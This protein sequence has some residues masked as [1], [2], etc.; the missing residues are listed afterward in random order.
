MNLWGAV[1]SSK[2]QTIVVADDRDLLIT[3]LALAPGTPS[4]VPVVVSLCNNETQQTF[5]LG[6]LRT[7][8]C[9]QFELDVNIAASSS[10]TLSVQGNGEVHFTGYFNRLQYFSDSSLDDEVNENDIN[11][12]IARYMREDSSSG[13]DYDGANVESVSTSDDAMDD[14]EESPLSPVKQ[15]TPPIQNKPLPEDKDNKSPKQQ[16][17]KPRSPGEKKKDQ[18][19]PEPKI[20]AKAED[21]KDQKP[22]SQEQKTPDQKKGNEPNKNKNQGGNQ[23]NKGKQ[24]GKQNT[25]KSPSQNQG[26]KQNPHQGQGKKN[27]NAPQSSPGSQPPNKKQKTQQ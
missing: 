8:I 16:D 23:Q 5:I 2:A 6:T 24:Q 13:E 3:R 9:E 26:Q 15:K 27:K 19:K 12:R 20:Q 4:K 25:G 1:V 18:K 11:Q 17:H 10:V 14:V 22:A 21:K 7:E